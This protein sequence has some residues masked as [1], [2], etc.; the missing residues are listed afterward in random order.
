MSTP[1]WDIAPRRG[2]IVLVE[3]DP[4]IPP[5][6]NKTR[7]CVIVS[8]DGANNASIRT[9]NSTFTVVPLTRTIKSNLSRPYQVV[10]EPEETGLP[11]AS[12]AQAEQVR[13]VSAR[14]VVR[15]IGHFTPEAMARLDSALRVHLALDT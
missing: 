12:T 5:E 1:L 2:H 7:P 14:R 9:W 10:V 4:A 8:N 11:F 15:V 3:L 13:A 6:Q